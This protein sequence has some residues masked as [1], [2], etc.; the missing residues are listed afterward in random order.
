MLAVPWCPASTSSDGHPDQ[1]A[2]QRQAPRPTGDVCHHRPVVTYCPWPRPLPCHRHCQCR[3]KQGFE[4]GRRQS[5]SGDIEG[6]KPIKRQKQ[7]SHRR[8][9]SRPWRAS[10][11]FQPRGS[12]EFGSSLPNP[13]HR[14]SSVSWRRVMM[15]RRR[16]GQTQ[17][18]QWH[19]RIPSQ[20]QRQQAALC[21][22]GA[23]FIPLGSN[24]PF[25][26]P[27]SYARRFDR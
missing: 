6:H 4:G 21:L 24:Q 11:L 3:T 25:E 17:S 8:L 2:S 14:W 22:N 15:L 1:A 12:Q 13:S 16:G 20:R 7:E 26:T 27:R 10:R 5:E 18:R 23:C 9:P 19:Q